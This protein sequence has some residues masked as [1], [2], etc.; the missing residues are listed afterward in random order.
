MCGICGK[1]NFDLGKN[2]EEELVRCMTRA[3]YRR[4]PD[5]ERFFF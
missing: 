5:D 2:V 3:L 4:G 1:F